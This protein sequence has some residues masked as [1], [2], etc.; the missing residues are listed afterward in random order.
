MYK[1]YMQAMEDYLTLTLCFSVLWLYW[2]IQLFDCS[3]SL[4]IIIFPLA[5]L[6]YYFWIPCP[7][8]NSSLKR[9]SLIQLP[10]LAPA[11]INN[12][13]PIPPITF[14][15]ALPKSRGHYLWLSIL[16]LAFGQLI[17]LG[18]DV[19]GFWNFRLWQKETSVWGPN[20]I[21]IYQLT[22]CQPN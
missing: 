22:T 15:T 11:S 18:W 13:A 9:N 2:A 6:S 20:P 3:I 21:Q 1:V 14:S 7:W 17:S 5:Y 4:Q 12:L 10:L 8:M 19:F 16:S